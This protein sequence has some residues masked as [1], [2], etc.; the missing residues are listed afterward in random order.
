MK[1]LLKQLHTSINGF[2]SLYQ[3]GSTEVGLIKLEDLLKSMNIMNKK[4]DLVLTS[5]TDA[6][7]HHHHQQ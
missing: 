6:H 1:D 5:V 7:H 4:L 2:N 3:I